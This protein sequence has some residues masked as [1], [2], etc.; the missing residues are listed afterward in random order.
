[1][2]GITVN[3]HVFH[4]PYCVHVLYMVSVEAY[5]M[6]TSA[7]K[8]SV[9]GQAFVFGVAILPSFMRKKVHVTEYR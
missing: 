2:E 6:G 1:M 8:N 4:I 3:V 7:K 5:F 9:L